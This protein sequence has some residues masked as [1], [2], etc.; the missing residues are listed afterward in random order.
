MLLIT[1]AGSQPYLLQM[2]F[3]ASMLFLA[4]AV[5][6]EATGTGDGKVLSL[7]IMMAR[8]EAFCQSHI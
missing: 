7:F 5:A 3:P 2:D 1:P 8:E 4:F 6:Q